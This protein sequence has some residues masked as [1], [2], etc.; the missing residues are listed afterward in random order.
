MLT[1]RWWEVVVCNIYIWGEGMERGLSDH[2]AVLSKIRLIGEWI[3]K[4]GGGWG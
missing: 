3:K 2:H 1:L 4:R